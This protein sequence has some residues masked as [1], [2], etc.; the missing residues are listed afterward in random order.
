LNEKEAIALLISSGCSPDVI[1]HCRSV[2][3][4]AKQI[5]IAISENAKRKEHPMNID[6]DAVFLGLCS[7]I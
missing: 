7:M 5:S 4:Y 6:I 1:E 3:E 2:A